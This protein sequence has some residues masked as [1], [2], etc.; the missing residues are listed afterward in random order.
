MANLLFQNIL[1][2]FR[3][4]IESSKIVPA[5]A[6]GF[7]SG[8]GLLVAQIAFGSFIFSGELA[9]Y[10]SLGIGLV[11][12]GNF[13]ACLIISIT[14]GYRG[15][16]AGLSPALV[17]I[18]ALIALSMNAEGEQ[19]FVT[20][21]V[22]F[23]ICAA[24]TGISSLVIGHFRIANL[25]RFIP[26]SV[27]CGFVAGI[28][29]A[30][31]LAAM[32]I[33]GVD[34]KW[35][36]LAANF[37]PAVLINWAPGIVFGTVI[38]I[39]VKRWRNSWLFPV[40]MLIAV[41]AYHVGLVFFNISVDEARAAGFLLSGSEGNIWPA[42]WPSDLLRVDWA[43]IVGQIHNML[44]LIMIA[45]ICI[46]MNI[47]GLE[48]AVNQDLNW[49]REF[50]S[51]GL[52]SIVSGLGGGT[53]S[54]LIV[55]ASLR[56]KLFRAHT[57]LTGIVAAAVIG[58]ALFLGDELLEIIPVALI[59]GIL[60]FAGLGMVDEGLVKSWKILPLS[61]YSVILLIF[62]IINL[63]GLIEGVT[64]GVLLTLVFFTVRLNRVNPIKDQFTARERHSK[65]A[66]SVPDRAILRAEGDRVQAYRLRGYIFFGSVVP[67]VENL[68]NSLTDATSCLMLDFTAVSG[69][70]FSAVRVFSKF[71]E[72]LHAD[73]THLVLVGLSD[74]LR[75][76]LEQNLQP[77]IFKTI[78]V[79][80]DADFGL[81]RCEDIIITEWNA[82]AAKTDPRGIRLFDATAD[83]IEFRLEQQIQFEE[84]IEELEHW[85]IPREYSANEILTGPDRSQDGLQFLLSGRASVYDHTG[86]R[87]RQFIPGDAIW[88][89]RKLDDHANLV[90]A[91]DSCRTMVMAPTDMHWLEETEERL[92]LKFY[93]YLIAQTFNDQLRADPSLGNLNK[94]EEQA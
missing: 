7:S 83:D 40:S 31:C 55:P 65:M 74:M 28:G 66:R 69:V 16:I 18:M 11:L 8:L 27:A 45:Y 87:L 37:D 81:E 14:S 57:R 43:A 59:G 46:I 85:L 24:A 12:F 71:L 68:R 90:L 4:E 35:R 19:L 75:S 72:K 63:I 34:L 56:S 15:A 30:V 32:S 13:A 5:L 48:L 51:T 47:A 73:E 62:F 17:I 58:C 53:V 38:Y 84:L 78:H 93:R 79:E 50:K 3:V 20:V 10:S 49:D 89:V 6:T 67:L 86:T 41:A 44:M 25:L 88:P 54:T 29:G 82:D 61:E 21:V 80:P 77:E 70:D 9:H 39:A 92:A 64:A 2:E 1:S 26:Y 36:N 33:S 22:A 52:A 91:D 94:P 23:M 60:V 76:G 42:L